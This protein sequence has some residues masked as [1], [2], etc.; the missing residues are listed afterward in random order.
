MEAI[1][2]DIEKSDEQDKKHLKTECVGFNAHAKR[3]RRD[4]VGITIRNQIGTESDIR[5]LIQWLTIIAA[6]LRDNG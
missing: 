3:I 1:F 5:E 6:D 4:L 2:Q